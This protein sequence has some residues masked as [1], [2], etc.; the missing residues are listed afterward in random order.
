MKEQRIK[1]ILNQIK[2]VKIAV[3]GDFC[4]DA[5]WIMDPRGSEV[6]VETGL[7]AHSIGRHYYSLGGASNIVANIAA[8]K[9]AGIRVISVIGDDIFGRE[10]TRQLKSLEVDTSSLI[11]QKENFDTVAFTKRCL[12][13]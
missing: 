13:P 8:L 9:P 12:K 7:Q 2:D 10:L 5:Y 6:S 1:E 3:Y 4:I 11:I